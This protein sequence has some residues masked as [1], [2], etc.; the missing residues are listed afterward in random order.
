[1]KVLEGAAVSEST[2]LRLIS[3]TGSRYA[4][5][6][7]SRETPFC[8]RIRNEVVPEWSATRKVEPQCRTQCRRNKCQTT[9]EQF[10]AAE[11]RSVWVSQEP[12]IRLTRTT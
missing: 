12:R 8:L 2:D 6:D 4:W 5:L 11:S 9:G 3:I 10:G 7:K 1:M